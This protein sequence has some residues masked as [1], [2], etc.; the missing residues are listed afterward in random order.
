M[1]FC[2]STFLCLAFFGAAFQARV[3]LAEDEPHA[4]VEWFALADDAPAEAEEGGGPQKKIIRGEIRQRVET[5]FGGEEEVERF[6]K[7]VDP[8]NAF[9]FENRVVLSDDAGKYWIGV[10]CREAT[11]ELRAQL[12][13]D[14][15]QGLVVVRI[16]EGSAAEKAGLKKYDVIAEVG[17]KKLG[18]V[19]DLAKIV[20]DVDGKMVSLSIFRAGKQQLV[21]ITPAE[22][23][24]DVLK[25]KI[26]RPAQG[27]YVWD[28]EGMS[29]FSAGK[30]PLPDD[31]SITIVRKG[32]EPTKI[33]VIHGK[34]KWEV[35][36]EQLDKLPEL[37]RAFVQ[38]SLGKPWTMGLPAPT[39]HRLPIPNMPV[40]PPGEGAGMRVVPLPPGGRP[41][42]V[43]P[44]MMKRLE[45]LD[46]RLEQ[47][48]DEIRRLRNDRQGPPQF[49]RH[50]DQRG[51]RDDRPNDDA[52][53]QFD[54][55]PVPAPNRK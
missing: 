35:T 5:E 3:S 20:N 52:E 8:L 4:V 11:P 40:P 55:R 9:F 10:E 29:H 49:E 30:L 36:D 1:Q 43:S 31:M 45:L 41:S 25:F 19:P 6:E 48:Q 21:D 23:P 22:R 12:G 13:L 28:M 47:M 32:K 18:R 2:K 15:K 16:S 14:E 27:M 54:D 46:R 7:P 37:V 38:Q 24:Q 34:E 50:L 53:L 17:G 26:A 33:T 44:E 51:P 39:P 42:E